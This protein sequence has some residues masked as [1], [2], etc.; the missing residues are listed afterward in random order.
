MEEKFAR[1]VDAVGS[2][3]R[4]EAKAAVKTLIILGDVAVPILVE[5]MQDDPKSFSPNYRR[6]NK[7]KQRQE[8]ISTL[9]RQIGTQFSLENLILLLESENPHARSLASRE[10]SEMRMTLQ[11]L[12]LHDRVIERLIVNLETAED[13]PTLEAA[14]F[15]LARLGDDVIIPRV[16][17]AVVDTHKNVQKKMAEGFQLA[18]E[19]ASLDSLMHVVQSQNASRAIREL[20]ARTLKYIG[21]PE[22]LAA[23]DSR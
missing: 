1:L 16:L 3:N 4:E 17:G 13:R 8:K 5:A 21:T 20:A 18:G 9:L 2:K 10:L 22:A 7:T 6:V 14:A 11:Y 23:I 12:E 15:A 19:R